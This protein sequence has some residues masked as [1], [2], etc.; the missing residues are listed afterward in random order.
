MVGLDTLLSSCRSKQKSS[1]HL[2]YGLVTLLQHMT[3]LKHTQYPAYTLW[4][5]IEFLQGWLFIEIIA[6]LDEQKFLA[7]QC[8]LLILSALL[9]GF[10]PSTK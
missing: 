2:L 7:R 4:M 9:F 8:L 1:A 6:N 10:K 3:C 5:P